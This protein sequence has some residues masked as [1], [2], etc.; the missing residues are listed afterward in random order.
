MFLNCICIKWGNLYAGEEVNR[1]YRAIQRNTTRKLR[2]FCMTDDA[3]GIDPAIEILPLVAPPFE[4]RMLA[5]LEAMPF[6]G[7]LRKIAMFRPDLIPDLQGPLIAFDLDLIITGDLD[8]L[9]DFAPGFVCMASPFSPP[10]ARGTKG[11]GSVIKFEPRLHSFLYETM[12]ENPEA[13]VRACQG[14]E[15]THTSMSAHRMGMLKNFPGHWI[16][17]FKKH[18]RPARPLGWL[19]PAKLPSQ[20]KVICFHGNPKISAALNGY[21]PNFMSAIGKSRWIAD[22]WY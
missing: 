2:F 4:A 1:L 10:G 19:L 21:Y 20:A 5:A 7:A 14:S 12:A 22:Y 17:S 11:E 3:S 16:R 13:C 6:K 9:A 8:E 18:C 15:Q